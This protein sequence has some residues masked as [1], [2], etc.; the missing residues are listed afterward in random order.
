MV[1]VDLLAESAAK[2]ACAYLRELRLPLFT[3]NP[4]GD[5]SGN[6][7]SDIT[8][9]RKLHSPDPIRSVP[10]TQRSEPMDELPLRDVLRSSHQGSFG[11]IILGVQ[12]CWPAEL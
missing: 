5:I 6:R 8:Y 4:R 7:A 10:I 3:E 9:F 2:L 12:R 11:G 1:L